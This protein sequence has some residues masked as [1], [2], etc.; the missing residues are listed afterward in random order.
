ML[1]EH[2]PEAGWDFGLFWLNERWVLGP[3]CHPDGR[4]WLE[5]RLV[6]AEGGDVHAYHK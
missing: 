4:G 2:L 5:P 6:G 3:R 1:S